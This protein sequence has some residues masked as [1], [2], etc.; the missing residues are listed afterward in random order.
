VLS[1]EDPLAWRGTGLGERPTAAQVRAHLD[2]ITRAGLHL[3]EVPVLWSFDEPRVY[4]E[5]PEWLRPYAAD[6]QLW[7]QALA[8][9]R[10]NL[11]PDSPRAWRH[12]AELWFGGNGSMG[13]GPAIPGDLYSP[14]VFP[15]GSP[16]NPVGFAHQVK[17][18]V[19]ELLRRKVDILGFSFEENPDCAVSR[20]QW[21]SEGAYQFAVVD[22]RYLIDPWARNMAEVR[23]QIFYDL[24]DPQDE[25]AALETYGDMFCWRDMGAA[26]PLPAVA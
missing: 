4:W 5:R 2:W 1:P 12:I 25:E 14:A 11:C 13:V 20:E 19:E 21:T 7:R 18:T 6:H 23:S 26:S 15:D 3:T 24:R 10:E 16:A 8:L 9:Q 17:Q 22:G